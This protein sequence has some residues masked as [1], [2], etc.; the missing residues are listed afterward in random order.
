MSRWAGHDEEQARE[1]IFSLVRITLGIQLVFTGVPTSLPLRCFL[2]T[3]CLNRDVSFRRGLAEE[4]PATP[5]AVALHAAHSHYDEC[6]AYKCSHYVAHLSQLYLPRSSGHRR[7]HHTDRPRARSVRCQR[8]FRRE[9][10][11]C[12]RSKHHSSRVRRQRRS[13]LPF[14]LPRPLLGRAQHQKSQLGMGH[15]AVD[16]SIVDLRHHA[17]LCHRHHHWLGS[18]KEPQVRS[19]KGSH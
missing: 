10:S 5:L 8:S 3:S 15:L 6:L 12:L 2:F 18:L 7:L 19:R 16:R 13:R 11:A 9:E 4:I 14:H 17:F 1:I